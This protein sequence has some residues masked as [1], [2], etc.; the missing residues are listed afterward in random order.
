MVVGH[1]ALSACCHRPLDAHCGSPSLV[2]FLEDAGVPHLFLVSH[3]GVRGQC[4][5]LPALPVGTVVSLGLGGGMRALVRARAH[6]HVCT[7]T[8]THTH[9]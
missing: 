6:T 5:Q 9:D 1:Q 3:A 4:G 8:H 7:H 2:I